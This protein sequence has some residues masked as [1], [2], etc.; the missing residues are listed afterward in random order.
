MGTEGQPI[1]VTALKPGMIV[2]GTITKIDPKYGARLEHVNANIQRERQDPQDRTSAQFPWPDFFV[3]GACVRVPVIYAGMKGQHNDWPLL[4]SGVPMLVTG[5]PASPAPAAPTPPPAQ[6]PDPREKSLAACKEWIAYLGDRSLDLQ[7]THFG[8]NER[9][10]VNAPETADLAHL[11]A[12][13][14]DAT[15]L[16]K[17]PKEEPKQDSPMDDNPPF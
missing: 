14:A 6:K 3:V 4:V 13:W 9:G 1:Q 17:A 2:Q 8:V 15:K 10:E 7:K 12:F 16:D 5:D 11:N